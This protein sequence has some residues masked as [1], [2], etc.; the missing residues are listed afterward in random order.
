MIWDI[1]CYIAGVICVVGPL[2]LIVWYFDA[3]KKQ[4]KRLHEKGN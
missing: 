4:V 3:A 2:L 1:G